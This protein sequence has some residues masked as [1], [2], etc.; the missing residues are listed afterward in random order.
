MHDFLLSIR[1]ERI[2]ESWKLELE[3]DLLRKA[4]PAYASITERAAAYR[5]FYLRGC[6]RTSVSAVPEAG[7]KMESP[8]ESLQTLLPD[9]R[10]TTAPFSTLLC[11]YDTAGNE[12]TFSPGGVRRMK[13]SLPWQGHYHTHD[14]IEILCVLQGSFEQILLGERQK[15][16]AGEFVIT[17]RNLEHADVLTGEGD[18]AVLFLQLQ[19]DYLDLLLSS[20]DRSDDLQR[21]LFHALRRQRREQSYL[22]LCP[23]SDN[24]RAADLLPSLLE[25]LTAE[26]FTPLEGSGDIIRGYL[27]RLL[28]ILCR[29]YD[30][31]L[32]SS[33]RESREKALL[34]ELERHIRLHPASVSAR[35]L[36]ERF[37]YHRNYFNL[38][39]KKYRGIGYRD[40]VQNVRL[41][42]AASLL[43]DTSL[44]VREAALTAGYHNSSHFYHL[45]ERRFGV[46]PAKYRK[47]RSPLPHPPSE[48]EE[49]SPSPAG[50]AVFIPV[51]TQSLP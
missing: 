11:L 33:D 49:S 12:A 14:Y 1:E 10:Q 34:Y 46:S 26:S 32:H 23:S 5:R 3:K 38:L 39:L 50:A 48:A 51:S 7:Q 6:G 40:Y 15:F 21:F 22:H 37:H 16:S 35:D 13:R 45:F 17:D 9:H 28:S 42:F 8:V 24:S 47:D 2:V 36:E 27:L 30:L 29:S 20:Y 41:D 4:H 19:A 18:A 31:K 44:S 43:L 25:H